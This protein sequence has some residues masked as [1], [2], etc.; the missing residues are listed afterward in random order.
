MD[1]DRSTNT[2]SMN[3]DTDT[4][5]ITPTLNI[6]ESDVVQ[7]F[8]GSARGTNRSK[9]NL[10]SKPQPVFIDMRGGQKESKATLRSSKR[11]PVGK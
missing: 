9:M 4:G 11:S 7:P 8:S 2:I 10:Q 6:P 5:N 1:H 3:I